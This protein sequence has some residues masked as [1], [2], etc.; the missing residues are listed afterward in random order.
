VNVSSIMCFED[1]LRL[2]QDCDPHGSILEF[3]GI[4]SQG[5]VRSAGESDPAFMQ[6]LR[7]RLGGTWWEVT[8]SRPLDH[9]ELAG[10]IQCRY[11]A[12]TLTDA[13]RRCPRAQVPLQT[14]FDEPDEDILEEEPEILMKRRR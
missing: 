2:W 8:S 1:L 4:R 14:P 9:R 5:D 7:E 12:D 3:L 6:V 13:V 11:L 10:G